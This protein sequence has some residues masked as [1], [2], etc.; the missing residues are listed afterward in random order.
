MS[1][2]TA[3]PIMGF[4]CQHSPNNDLLHEQYVYVTGAHGPTITAGWSLI[5][6]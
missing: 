5:A 6:P 2:L 3:G 1:T 4:Q